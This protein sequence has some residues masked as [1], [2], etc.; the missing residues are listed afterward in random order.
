MKPGIIA[1]CLSWC[2]FLDPL[3]LTLLGKYQS[4]I[5]ITRL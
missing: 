4:V 3:T 2:A 1:V 5:P